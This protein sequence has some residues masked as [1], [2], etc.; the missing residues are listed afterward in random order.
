VKRLL[1]NKVTK[2]AK[3][4]AEKLNKKASGYSARQQKIALVIFCFLFTVFSTS[5]LIKAFTGKNSKEEIFERQLHVPAH[6]GKQFS[7]PEPVITKQDYERIEQFK[8]K[9]DSAV[10]KTRPHLMDSIQL[11]EQI[12]QS[13]T[14]K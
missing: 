5:V 13:Q 3:R 7:M 2:F 1:K 11:F 4:Y 8:S 6:V 14:K 10:L 9:I 12:Y